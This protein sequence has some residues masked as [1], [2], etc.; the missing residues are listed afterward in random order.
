MTSTAQDEPSGSADF[1][2]A[3]SGREQAHRFAWSLVNEVV[4]LL[5]SAV[6]FLA[7]TQ[8]FE[9]DTYGVLG[10]LMAVASI[11]APIATFG[12]AWL[13]LKRVVVSTDPNKDFDLAFSVAFFGTVATT[14]VAVALQPLVLPGIDR[15]LVALTLGGQLVGLS[16]AEYAIQYAVALG[17]LRL[18]AEIRIANAT[19]RLGGLGFFVAFQ[20][21]TLSA[22]CWN[23]LIFGLLGTAVAHL[24]LMRHTRTIV[25]LRTTPFEEYRSGIAYAF[26]STAEGFL[27]ASDRPILLRYGHDAGAGFYAAGYRI[28]SLALV[29]LMALIR[30]NDKVM[31]EAG[32]HGVSTGIAQGRRVTLQALALSIG[33]SLGLLVTA[34]FAVDLV[35]PSEYAETAEVIRLLCVL[36]AIKALQFPIGN[37]LTASG[38]QVAR[39]WLTV[40]ATIVNLV[41]NLILIPSGNWQA[42]AL[43]TIIAETLL[44]ASLW[45]YA[46]VVSRW[47]R[48][49]G[50]TAVSASG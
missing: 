15:S 13:L 14:I 12:S 24:V 50:S 46:V 36:P 32:S 7:L 34:G 23:L 48:R 45:I 41:L 1:G 33:V 8:F 42:A 39:L 20:D 10:G 37:V 2:A 21:K 49:A 17:Q 18:A 44:A 29:P 30:A 38:H 31:F 28:A 19:V 4:G 43:T 27:S 22:W 35:L 6:L 11:G 47:E 5:T 9:P 26:G 3:G 16:L 40:V 25:R